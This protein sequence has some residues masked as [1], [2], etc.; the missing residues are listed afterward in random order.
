MKRRALLLA[1]VVCGCPAKPTPNPAD[2]VAIEFVSLEDEPID[3]PLAKITVG[4]VDLALARKRFEREGS[5]RAKPLPKPLHQHT[6]DKLVERHLLAMEADRLN[7]KA[8][9]TAVAK[10]MAALRAAH[11]D[12]DFARV[13]IETYQTE[14]ELRD[15]IRTQLTAVKLLTREALKGTQPSE[16]ALRERFE[17]LSEEER[18]RPERVRARQIMVTTEQ[19][20]DAIHKELRWKKETFGDIARAR[21][22]GPEASRGGD[23]GWFARGQM[24]QVFDEIC[25]PLQPE[26]VSPVMA[27][28]LGF[29]ICQVLEREPA[30]PLTFA[31]VAPKLRRTMQV[32]AERDAR[33]A[34]L[35]GLREGVRIRFLDP[36]AAPKK[37]DSK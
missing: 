15:A 2:R 17:A 26:E 37:D 16:D 7:V 6:I 31:E 23:L 18:V 24:P 22:V 27:S 32:E 28:E 14:E 19:E 9:T 1:L 11:D 12:D 25:F 30:R 10:E 33:E 4:E 29:H 5:L 36:I 21:S 13:L 34:Y 20:A 8:S 3:H 35:K